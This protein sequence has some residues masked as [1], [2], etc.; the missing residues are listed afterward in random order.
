VHRFLPIIH[1]G[2]CKG[3]QATALVLILLIQ[4]TT[5]KQLQAS[6]AA[7]ADIAYQHLGGLQY[8]VILNFYRDCGGVSE[9]Q[10][11]SMNC[12]SLNG[13]HNLNFYAQKD[14]TSPNG[15]EITL[16]CPQ[17]PSTCNGGTTQGIRRW[18][19]TATITL[20]SRQADWTFS[21]SIC[22]RNCIITTIHN[23]C[24][25]NSI[26]YVEA[27]LDNLN[28]SGNHSPSFSNAPVAFVCLG[29]L[30]NFNH[31]VTDADGD[32]LSFSL[33]TPKTSRTSQVSF[34]PP[35]SAQ[36]PLSSSTPFNLN[37]ITGN[38]SFT[39]VQ[40]QVGVMAVRVSEFRNG[41]NIGSVI[42]DMQVYTV[43]CQNNLPLL[44]GI[45]GSSTYS[46]STCAGNTLC[47]TINSADADP[48][49][50][51]SVSPGIPI[52]GATITIQQGSRPSIDFCWTPGL[53]DIRPS[54]YVF[55]ATV[56]DNSC[57]S[58]GVQVFT[59]SIFVTGPQ[60]LVYVSSPTCAG[61]NDGR[62]QID[63]LAC[64]SCT[65]QWDN[66]STY[67][68]R[69]NLAAGPYSLTSYDPL[70]GC[71]SVKT[72][73][74]TEPDSI[75]L[76]A[77]VTDEDCSGLSTG[78]ITLALSGGRPPYSI[79]WS[80][81]VQGPARNSLSSGNYVF[82]VS[83]Q[84]GC[85]VIDTITVGGTGNPLQLSVTVTPV[86]CDGNS[87]GSIGL[88]VSGGQPPYLY[89]SNNLNC[90]PLQTGLDTGI[91]AIAVFDNS[92]CRKDTVIRIERPYTGP[93]VAYETNFP[94]CHGMSNGSI[95]N[96]N[97]GGTPYTYQWNT[98]ASTADIT[99]LLPGT[100][101]VSITGAGGCQSQQTF[102][103]GQPSS[104]SLQASISPLS[105][106]NMN[107]GAVTTT[108]S[109]GTPP[110]SWLWSNGDTLSSLSGLTQGD[111]PVLIRDMN[112]CSI[113]DTIQITTRW[114]PLEIQA[115]VTDLKCH[116][117]SDGRILLNVSGGLPPYL[118]QWNTGI[119]PAALN[120]LT[121]GTYTVT[122]TDSSGCSS[123]KQVQVT[124]PPDSLN[125]GINIIPPSCM[126]SQSGRITLTPSGGTPPYSI[127]W[128][129]GSSSPNLGVSMPGTY[130]Y[131][132]TDANGCTISGTVPVQDGFNL[133]ISTGGEPEICPGE[134][135]EIRCLNCGSGQLQW[136]Y[137]NTALN[138][139]H[140]ASFSTPVAGTYQLA[141]AN[142]CG[143]YRSNPVEISL[144]SP[145]SISLGN[146]L[147]ICPGEKALLKA[148]GGISYEWR[149]EEYLDDP[150][151]SSP[152]ASPETTTVYTVTVQ[153][154]AGCTASGDIIVTVAC[155]G[156]DIPNGIS[157]N[158]DGINDYFVIE[159]IGLYPD[160]VIFI[161]NRWGNLIY[162][163]KSY[164]NTWNGRS[165]TGT[166]QF[167]EELPEGTYFY[168]LDMGN[169]GKPIQGF[170][171]LRR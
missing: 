12:R 113:T 152:E 8:R 141:I 137:N 65:Y 126:Q 9:P 15:T 168:I 20:P 40:P 50:I 99:G 49:Q 16:P 156:K 1:L 132:I 32:S 146:N 164:D 110:Y 142:D 136:Y 38:M 89:Q 81:G 55:T 90:G 138:G 25:A 73:V 30:F 122:V 17:A 124:A 163:K 56:R 11:V 72:I 77:S 5:G 120:Q 57:P 128:N 88:S 133:E 150:A 64:P 68:T 52:P 117:S 171:V 160:N 125:T 105:C 157:P 109:G 10:Q 39:P 7:G 98:G 80:D 115:S 84:N 41:Q 70:S 62:I 4:L 3:S 147:I 59:Y 66:G 145:P 167:G 13:N 111:Y 94:S 123:I 107:D 47:F 104:L 78:S 165:N 54:P 28:T 159:D 140:T 27:T 108:V 60:P 44:S 101:T 63:T 92:G 58:N 2:R 75:V 6:H 42:R 134:I 43:P 158:G 85:A 86:G 162:K 130:S 112:N 166:V 33:I 154:E 34:I 31:G 79:Q 22:C 21:N 153:N 96:M 129:T 23:P 35:S 95:I 87:N 93:Q 143:T 116:G 14:T 19:Y 100:Y 119:G 97:T 69:T 169:N 29:Q 131:R 82:S 83:D 76:S 46:T 170:I 91:Y 151:S 67:P 139:A 61:L 45:N 127:L 51:L 24:A 48:L 135:A 106:E 71:S 155:D 103:L 144:K 148:E 37:D 161:Y 18:T 149:P 121:A 53:S 74:L 36:Q 118:Y 26:Q 102:Q 114:M